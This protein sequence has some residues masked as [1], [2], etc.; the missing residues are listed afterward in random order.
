MSQWLLESATAEF[1]RFA[2]DWDQL[3]RT[4]YQSHPMFDS[5]FIGALLRHFGTSGTLMAVHRQNGG[6]LLLES[7]RSNTWTSFLPAQLQAAPIMLPPQHYAALGSLFRGLPGFPILIDWLAQDPIFSP[8][9]PPSSTAEVH[10]QAA[11]T[12]AIALNDDFENYWAL[13]PK[14]LRNN[15]KRYLKR[16]G[17]N[18][19][20]AILQTYTAEADMEAALNR[21]SDL[22]SAGWKGHNGT[23]IERD[24]RQ[25]HFYRDV[26][27]SY[28]ASAQARVYE[29]QLDGKVVASRLAISGGGMLLMLKTTYDEAFK[30]LA[31]GRVLLYKLLEQE[32]LQRQNQRIEFYTNATPDQLE[33]ATESRAIEHVTMYR[34]S[35]YANGIML[36]RRLRNIVRHRRGEAG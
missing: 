15:I 10:Q 22:E 17:E 3:N 5:R 24:N 13:R 6:M 25:W 18:H 31:V 32:F 28:A 1:D 16:I 33:W 29:L 20:T 23:A 26:L 21:Y 8:C 34:S 14:K 27:Q 11:I 35:L 30:E 2:N 9:P 36:A 7:S 19:Q 12:M 4:L